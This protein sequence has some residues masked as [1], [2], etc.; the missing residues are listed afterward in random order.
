MKITDNGEWLEMNVLESFVPTVNLTDALQRLAQRRNDLIKYTDIMKHADTPKCREFQKNYNGFYRV[1]RNE[2]WREKYFALMEDLK[3]KRHTTFEEI[4]SRL[5]HETGLIEAS[6]ASKMLA[7]INHD[8]PIW[9]SVVL[10]TLAPLQ[11]VTIG[12]TAELRMQNIIASYERICRWYK[13]FMKTECARE[14]IERFDREFPECKEFSSV[15]KIDFILW[16]SR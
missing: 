4:L 10:K 2:A 14:W 9:D 15:K 6:Y 3:G 12:K 11:L 1:R 5:Y 8:M 16:A 7:T 13:G